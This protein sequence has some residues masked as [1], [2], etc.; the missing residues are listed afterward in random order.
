MGQRP[1]PGKGRTRKS[2]TV[3]A[4]WIGGGCVVVAAII[5][6]IVPTMLHKDSSVPRPP[7]TSPILRV[8]SA[9]SSIA[10]G[11]VAAVRREAGLSGGCGSWIVP[12]APQAISSVSSTTNWETW[13]AQN[14]SID[15]TRA[16][17][18]LQANTSQNDAVSNLDVTIQGR[19]SVQTILTGIQFVV[20]QRSSKAIK[21]GLVKRL[22]GGPMDARYMVVNLD[23]KP[24]KIVT[25]VRD[26]FPAPSGEPWQGTPVEFPY[27]VTSTS[28][29]VFK[30]VAY[31]QGDVSW[32]A[33][34]N[35]SANGKNGQ[36]VI[37]DDGKPFETAV[38]SRATD[39]YNFNGHNWYICS[40][41]TPQENST[42]EC[43]LNY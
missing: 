7:G 15:A 42:T 33:E 26:P 5:S 17:F 30:I 31:T 6:A 23:S 4:A 21:G 19:S 1:N 22:C 3:K 37:S 40:K 18:W 36:T 14:N 41:N 24:A 2:V 35:W 32:Y 10:D 16:E 34:L 20:A 39:V 25:S 13:L 12:K 27:Y 43:A 9:T 29:E 11:P 8:P 28:A 38:A